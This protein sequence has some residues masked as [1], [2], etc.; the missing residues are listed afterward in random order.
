MPSSHRIARRTANRGTATAAGLVALA[1]AGLAAAQEGP[2][3]PWQLG[4]MTAP[5]GPDLAEIELAEPYIFLDAEGTRRLM[6]LTQNPIDGNELAT[7]AP[8][9]E[10]AHWFVV[11]EFDETGYVPDDEKADL[12]ADAML[13]AVRQGTE[14]A[15][16]E[17][18]RRGW[19]TMSILG[20]YEE[21]AYDDTTNDL[22]WAILAEAGGERNVNR[23]VK[24]LGRRGVMTVT[25]VA[26]PEEMGEVVPEVDALLTGYRYRTGSTY[27]EYVPGT[28]K[29]ATYGLTALVVGGGAAALVK[30]G[31][32]AKIWKPLVFGIA[33]IGAG[34]KRFF[35]SG[36]SANHDPEKPIG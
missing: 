16:E 12:D 13:E 11:F 28:D 4:P 10:G 9:R 22:R 18:S 35:F 29:L 15:N 24:R 34:I 6:E 20:W 31:L 23:I 8:R 17:R 21:P 36:R 32:L 19:Q 30:S 33:A 25:L 14:A 3:L 5:I 2:A 7:V 27:A 26:S 1:V